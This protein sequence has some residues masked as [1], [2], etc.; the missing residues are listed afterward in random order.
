MLNNVETRALV[1]MADIV[2]LIVDAR[3][4]TVESI[5][6]AKEMVPELESRLSGVVLNHVV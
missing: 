2:I 1:G 6:S 4:T 3:S 5:A